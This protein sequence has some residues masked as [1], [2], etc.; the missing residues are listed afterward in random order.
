M[1]KNYLGLWIHLG[2]LKSIQE[3]RVALGYTLSN[4]YASLMLS[5]QNFCM[6]PQ[7]DIHAMHEPVLNYMAAWRSKFLFLVFKT[8]VISSMFLIM[9]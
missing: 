9:H 2:G 5:L 4:S 1:S 6:H 7:L 3:A 8:I